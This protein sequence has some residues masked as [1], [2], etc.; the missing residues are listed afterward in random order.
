M[1]NLFRHLPSVDRV[2][3][4][5]RIKK[6]R[7]S[8]PESL[9]AN[10]IRSY[11]DELR[12]LI[13]VGKPCPPFDHMVEAILAQAE[14]L[15]RPNL[16]PL[17]NATGVIVHTN[18]GRATLSEEAIEAMSSVARSYT[19]LE[20]DIQSGER[21]SRHAHLENLLCRLTG[22]EAAMVVNNNA[23]AVLLG[24]AAVARRKEVIVSRG[25]AVEIGGGFRI[26][27]V[28]RQSGAKLVEVGTTNRTYL[29]DY[30]QAV[31]LRTAA[32]LRVHSSNFKIV[33]FTQSVAA[34][35]LVALAGRLDVLVLDDL[36]SGC[37][38][39]TGQFGLEHEPM[40]Q[41]SVAAGVGL[42][43][44]SGDKLLGGPQAGII[45]G[46]KALVDKLKRHPFARAVRLD[47]LR[48]A[49]LVATLFHYL[50][51]EALE[52]IPVWRMIS[53]P[54]VDVE[55]RAVEWTQ[56][57]GEVARVVPGESVVGG[58]SIP[59]STLPTKL[60]AVDLPPSVGERSSAELARQLRR[61]EPPIIGRIE[62]KRILLDPRTVL[63][64]EDAALLASL[65]H[66]L[67]S[68]VAA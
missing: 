43:F 19:N 65:R 29:A 57:L 9:I 13:S 52:K 1:E 68:V 48:L 50:K 30:E 6:I 28:M 49:A 12:H 15:Q 14:A 36:G 33:G 5:E 62:R 25:Q 61:G 20:F 55:R 51:A 8:Y 44:F 46:K 3:S 40:V 23:S 56:V 7:R 59:G 63:P 4:D 60:V 24:L 16:R 27:D 35:D 45:V 58:G 42:T 67:K 39:D 32:F 54:L 22:A 38:L 34:E 21:G 53:M 10:L 18:L 41:E 11:L 2:L 66:L 26:P 47:K 31:T 17:I 64:E 37:V